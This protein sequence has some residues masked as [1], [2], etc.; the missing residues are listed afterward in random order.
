ML[1]KKALLGINL[2]DNLEEHLSF[3]GTPNQER[4]IFE[5]PVTNSISVDNAK[6]LYYYLGASLISIQIHGRP[7]I[8]R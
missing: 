5:K 2:G 6:L 1:N 3:L 4:S 8:I 7:K